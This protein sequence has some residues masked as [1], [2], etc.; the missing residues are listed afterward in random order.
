MEIKDPMIMLSEDIDRMTNQNNQQTTQQQRPANNTNYQQKSFNNQQRPQQ[1]QQQRPQQKGGRPRKPNFFKKQRD[2]FGDQWSIKN[3]NLK[4]EIP[5]LIIDF[6]KGN[7]DRN[8]VLNFYDNTFRAIFKAT[9]TENLILAQYRCQANNSFIR[10]NEGK[11]PQNVAEIINKDTVRHR[12][13]SDMNEFMRQ[14]DACF[15]YGQEAV[16]LAA[17]QFIMHMYKNYNELIRLF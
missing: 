10:E 11:F 15:P 2:R 3:N 1:H 8:D 14:L 6:A 7:V 4:R 9:V 13:W 5:G 16:L 17:D 12:I